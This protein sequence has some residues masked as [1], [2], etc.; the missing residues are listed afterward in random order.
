MS[1]TRP[2]AIPSLGSQLER[3]RLEYR[4]TRAS[5]AIVALRRNANEHRRERQAQRLRQAIA[6]FETQVEAMNARL[7]DLASDSASTQ[8]QLMAHPTHPNEE[9]SSP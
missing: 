8:A 1:A 2:T 7:Q 5:L 3:D 4:V 6:D 9:A